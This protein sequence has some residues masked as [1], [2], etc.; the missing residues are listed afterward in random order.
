MANPNNNGNG[1]G[2][3]G[4]GGGAPPPNPHRK[5]TPLETQQGLEK[6]TDA[7]KSDFHKADGSL[8]TIATDESL[9]TFGELVDNGRADELAL[10]LENP[11]QLLLSMIFALQDRVAAL[12][13]RGP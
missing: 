8:Y 2:N 9:K 1:N 7:F 3:G 13:R 11:T 4:N 10:Y 6:M 5:P 12:E